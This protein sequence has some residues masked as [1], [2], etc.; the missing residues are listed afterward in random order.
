[1]HKIASSPTFKSINPIYMIHPTICTLDH[2]ILIKRNG[3]VSYI[4]AKD[5]SINDMVCYPK[6][7]SERI[8]QYFTNSISDDDYYYTKIDALKYYTNIKTFVYDITVEE[9]HNFIVNNMI[10]H[11]CGGSETA[12]LTDITDC[13]PIVWNLSFE[14]FCNES[15]VSLGD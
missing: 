9:S 1:M 6:N 15:R 4:S 11:N 12:Y 8:E 13:D 3:T 14:R 2:K 5:I 7:T 10:V